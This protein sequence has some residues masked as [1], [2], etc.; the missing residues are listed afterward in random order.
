MRQVKTNEK[1]D[2]LE[3]D[4][5]NELILEALYT[6]IAWAEVQLASCKGSDRLDTQPIDAFGPLRTV[7]G[8]L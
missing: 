7:E 8:K 5:R 1:Y 2:L 3:C 6:A 4:A